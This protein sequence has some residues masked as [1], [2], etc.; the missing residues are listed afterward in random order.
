MLLFRL[1]QISD[2]IC[3]K[4]IH[5]DFFILGINCTKF[6][7]SNNLRNAVRLA[8]QYAHSVDAEYRGYINAG[9]SVKS[10]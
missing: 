1:V 3:H 5:Y 4:K 6:H 7:I 2:T 8:L 10:S 9:L